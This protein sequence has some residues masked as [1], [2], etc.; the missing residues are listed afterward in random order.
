ME[1]RGPWWRPLAGEAGARASI[2][3]SK[4]LLYIPEKAPQILVV[5]Y[6]LYYAR[7]GSCNALYTFLQDYAMFRGTRPFLQSNHRL[8]GY[9]GVL[10]DSPLAPYVSPRYDVTYIICC[11]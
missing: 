4:A 9:S 1:Y 5:I 6:R 11:L 7:G 3:P 8:L 2:Q 10:F